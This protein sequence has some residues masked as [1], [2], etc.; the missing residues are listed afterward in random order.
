MPEASVDRAV[1]RIWIN[2]HPESADMDAEKDDYVIRD[3]IV[4]IPKS[5]IAPE[6][7]VI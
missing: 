1:P 5:V 2:T 7:T 6:N 3:G 4:V